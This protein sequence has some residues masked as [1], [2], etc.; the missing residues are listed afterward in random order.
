MALLNVKQLSEWLQVKPS[1]VYQWAADGKIPALKI[2]GAI[3]FRRDDI[4]AWLEA[5]Q[6]HQPNLSQPTNR[7]S[8]AGEIDALIATAKREVYTPSRGKP[9]QDRA[10][11]G[12]E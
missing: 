10:K 9:D 6:I 8:P 2:Q 7:R 1:S 11:P 12:G 5:C 4:E 3:R